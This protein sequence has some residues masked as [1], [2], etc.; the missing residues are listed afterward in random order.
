MNKIPSIAH[1]LKDLP[2]VPISSLKPLQGNLKELSTKNYNKLKRSLLDNG[3]FLPFFVWA[4]ES[5]FLDG[6][7]RDRVFTNEGWDIDVPVVYVS[8]D[9]EEEAKE[10]LLVISSQYGRVTQEGWDEFTV[11]LND[12]WIQDTVHFDALPFVFSDFGEEEEQESED[13]E[14]QT[15]RADELC[16]KWGVELGQM[17]R[18]PSRTGG[19]EHRL[20]CG[21]CTDGAVVER[22]MGGGTASA[23]LTDPPY[24]VKYLQGD[25]KRG[26]TQSYNRTKKRHVR[27]PIIGD[28]KPFDPTPFLDYEIVILWGANNYADRLP[29]SRGWLVWDKKPDIA[30]N[31]FSDGELAWTNL[32]KV[33]RVFR[34]RWSGVIRASQN[35]E[36]VNHPTEKPV[37]L[38]EWCIETTNVSG[39]VLDPYG[40]SGTTIIAAENLAR[41]CRAVEISPSYCAV[42]LDRYERAFGIK[43][44]LVI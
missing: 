6:H 22:V 41:Q 40:G 30:S 26:R 8:A 16:D 39:I 2:H 19:Q 7:Q 12:D 42:A 5:K 10:K 21:D 36:I 28:D 29:P 1:H 34:H 38:F 11:D 17:W 14:P 33:L 27:V 4:E 32:D 43:P 25:D 31:D 37:K 3:I 9:T 13:A 24:G 23:C 18:L 44:E 20:I 35:G 15:N